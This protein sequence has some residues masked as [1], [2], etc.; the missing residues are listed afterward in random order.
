MKD[1]LKIQ[2][3]K[4]GAFTIETEDDFFKMHTLTIASGKRGSGK[5]VAVSNIA[6]MTKQKG[7][8]DRIYLITP[9]YASNKEIWEIA[10]IEET[11][12]FEP[13]KTVLHN[14]KKLIE[15]ER[16]EW[17]DFLKKKELYKE[18]QRVI[19]GQSLNLNDADIMQKLLT[20]H[21]LGFLDSPPVW[22][23]KKEVPPRLGVI[24]DDCLGSELFLPT[25]KLT[26]F[27]CNHRHHG[28]GLG[29]SVWMLVQSYCCKEGIAKPIREQCT[30]L[31]LFKLVQE[32]NLQRIWEE[33]DVPIKYEDFKKMC[34]DVHKEPHAFLFIDFAFKRPEHR[35]RHNLDKFLTYQEQ[36]LI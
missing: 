4:K 25:A 2:P 15:Q 11:D 3:P 9:T 6:R 16:H 5:S 12:I 30:A 14:L 19:N 22:K 24:I 35:F 29:I 17:D 27:C 1:Y 34:V 21:E 28:N 10:G 23:Y 33:S 20:Y 7:Y 36:E 32:K 8:M 18:Y 26:S 31:L 13:K